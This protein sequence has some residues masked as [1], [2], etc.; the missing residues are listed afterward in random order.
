MTNTESLSVWA[1]IIHFFDNMIAH[2]FLSASSYLN[3]ERAKHARLSSY[4]PRTQE[5]CERSL[6]ENWDRNITRSKL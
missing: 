5:R 4:I 1:G 3:S 2:I 6:F